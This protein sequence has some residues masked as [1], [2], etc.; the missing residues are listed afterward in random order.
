MGWQ[1]IIGELTY[2][3]GAT[4]VPKKTTDLQPLP[5]MA[6]GKKL[7]KVGEKKTIAFK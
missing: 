2:M 7:Q 5:N 6:P 4:T 3:R 1:H